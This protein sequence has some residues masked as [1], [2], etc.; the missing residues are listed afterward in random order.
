MARARPSVAGG[1]VAAPPERAGPGRPRRS[2]TGHRCDPERPGLRAVPRTPGPGAGRRA[3]KLR[4]GRGWWALLLLQLHLLRALAQDDVA[5]YFKTE[6]GLPQ[7]HLEGNRLVLTCLAEGSWP[8][9]FKWIRNDS[10]LTTYSSEYKYII[11]SLQKLDA[12]FYRCVVRNR[13]GALL[14]RKSEIQVAY[15]GNFMDTDQRKTVSQGHA[16]LLNL[17][18][19]VSCPRPQVTWF[20][21]GHKIIPSSRIAITL[22]N[23]LVILATTA[24]DAGAYYVQAVNERNGENKTSPFIHLSIA[25][26]TGTQEAMAPIIVVAPGNRS[27]VAGSSETT[28]ECIAN[29]RPVEEL[30]VHWKRNGVRLTSGLHSYGRRLTII[31]PTSADTGM[32]VCEATLRGSTFEPARAR[33]FLSII[34]PPYFTAE[35]ESR[36]LGEVEEAVDIP[37]RAMGVPL[38]TLQWYKDAVPLS[39]LQN[40]RYKVLPSGGLHIQKL[41]PEDSGIFQCFASNEGGEIQTHTYLDVT[42]IAPAFTQ[43]P[44]DTTVTDGMTAVLRCEVS[45]AP[46]PAIT[47]KRGNHI[48]ASGS[49]RIPR[50]MLLE[51][52]GLRIA[53]VFIQD[54]GNYTCY[55]ANTEASVNAS[56]MLT[57]WNRT[58]IVHPPEDRVVIK[59]TTATLCCGATHDPRTSLRYVWKK[60]NMVITAS[61]SSRIVVEKDGS[62]VISQTW[63]GDIGDYTCEIISEGGSDSRTARLEVIELPHPPQNLLA[64]LSPA[65]S[66]SV[67]LSWVRPFDGNSPVLY[68]IVQVSENNSPWKVHLSNVGPEMTGVTVSGLTPART[69]QFRVCAVNQ[70]GKGQYSTETSRLMLPEEPPSAPPKNIVASGRTNQSIMVQWQPPPETEHN[71]V[72]RGYILRYRLAGLPGEH[73]QRNISSPEVNYCLVTDLIIWTQYEIQVAAYNGAG[74]GVFSRAVTEYTLQGVPT[75][76]PQ[77]VQAEA[78]NSTT[79][80]FL[81]NPPPQQFIN[82]INQGYKLLAWPADAPETVTV[83]TIAPDFHGIH[84]GY[85]TNLKKFTAYFTSVLCFTTPGDGPPSSPQLVWTH[86]DKPGAVGH[87]SFT[88]IL[89]TSLKVSWQEPLERNGIIMGYQISWEVYGRNDSRLTHTLNST[90]HE[91]KIQGLSSLTTYT[92]DVAALTAAGV[93]VTTSSTISSGVP[94]DL[95]GAPSNLVISNISPR[96]AT[97]QF[98]PGYDGKTAICRWIVEGQVGAIGDEEEWVTLYEEENEPD[99][100]MLEI[101]NLTPYTHYRFRMRQVNI[102]GPSPFSQ[103]SRV[104]QTLQAPPDVAPTSL[105]VRTASET[106]LRL[107]WV[108]L[109][110]SQYNGNP[111]S[112]GYRVK[113]WRSD[114]PTSAL[115]QVVSDR[116]ERELTIEELEEWTEYELRM[117]AFNAIGAGPWS[118]L[119]RGRTRESV[120]SAAPENVSAEAVSSTQILLTWA[121]VPEQ[122]QNGLILGYKV[123][124]RAK[125]LDPEPRSHVVRG[126]H[127]QSALLAGLRKFVV[128][129]LQVL[130]FTRIGNGVPSS[131]LVLERTKDDTP[132]PPVRLVFP[133]VRLTAVRIVWQPPEEPNGVI[134]GYQIAY[135]LASGSPHTFTTVEVGATVRQFTATELAPESAYIFRLSAK[136]RQGWGEPLEATVITTEKRERP[137]PPRELLVPQAEVTARSLRLQW[138]PGS[139]GASPI[140]Y[141]TVQ[142]R[143]LPGGEWQTY[144]SSI[145]HE[146]TACAVERLR[147]FTSYKLRLKA[148]NDIGDSD[149]SV[150]TEAVTTLQDVPGEPPGSVSAT[151]HTTS[152]VLIQWQPPRDE[153]LNGLLQGYRIY[154]RELASETGMSPE[155]KTLQSPSALRAELTA[156][157]SFKTVNSSSSLTTYELT[158]LKKYRRYE[159]IM[160]AYNIIGESPASVPVEVFVGEAAPAMAPQ[161]VQVTPLT[162]SQLE[163][164]WDPP[165]PES[166]NGNIQ[167]YKV[168]YWEADSRNETEK[169]KVLFL[170]EPVVKIKDLTSHTKYLVSISAFNAAGDGPKS[171][172][173]QGRTHQA[174]PGTPSFLAFSEITSTTLNVSWG[175]PSAANGILQGYR[176]VYEPLAPVQGV[177]KVVTV[178]VK[179][180][181]QRWLKVRD[182]TK[183]VT[184]FFRV[185][186]RTIAYGPE[187]QANVTA[188][189]AEGSPG[190]PRNVLVTK[191]ASELTLQWIE[192]NAGTTPTTGYVIEARPSDEGLWDMFAKDIPRSATSYTVDLD[193]LRQGV[194]YEFRVVAVNKA[195][196]GEPSRPSIAVSAQAEAPFY[197]EWWFLL[198]M[199]LSSLLLI[200]LVVFVLVLHGQSKKYKNCSTGKG[201]SNM[202][203]T[204]TLD[205]GG[206]AALE[207]NSRHLNVKST[208]SK[209]NGTRS[210]PRPSPGGLHYSDEDICNKYNGAVLTESVN[211]KEKSVDGSESEASDSDY[212]EALPKHSFVNHYMSDPTYY[213]SWKRRPPAAAPHRYEAVAGAEAGPHLHT[214]ITTQ[215]AGGVYT[216]AGPGARAPLTGFSSFV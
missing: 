146:A 131:P 179:G 124:Y 134:L 196:F 171:D 164:T 53:P 149:F 176:V 114:Q 139:D 125:D 91:Y 34:E 197:E 127:T 42:N 213:N 82:G 160:T 136:T 4:P 58:S 162:A 29:A 144:S 150:E 202:E 169:M 41:S 186:A 152:S 88:E 201:I 137:A 3:A 97:L 72:L 70:V 173:C 188:G 210:P 193:K 156:Q 47:W 209:K 36:I 15:M 154:Y 21:E 166:Q 187:L 74:L 175:E 147:P 132:G 138:V 116:L 79:V 76:P 163:V 73:Q 106:S 38:P 102:V 117:Q 57:V 14:Q 159:V 215:S 33:A 18:P 94:P 110:D 64:S 5:P 200:L 90:T 26:D 119:V 32:Y 27:V 13:M 174:A 211:L 165:P 140:R 151:P 167:G 101:P 24:S 52:G 63:S 8:L 48:L 216:P 43:R 180:N 153:S 158:H 208:F 1:G 68:Y 205:N 170:P 109:P 148:T 100:Q 81:W 78:V 55:A 194:T 121:S 30:S 177:S 10:E 135:R 17:M 87:L 143:E 44:A 191:S 168:Y 28:L 31:N 69:Y 67:T 182:L 9:E 128:Y 142:V 25:R 49:V 199:A 61:S 51:S 85:I 6:P 189:P 155:P 80:H 35:P 172:P 206:F 115:A 77:N 178:D 108:P 86:E 19:I 198:V 40:P 22:E 20:R 118:E 204:V 89:D 54:A 50:F 75:A 59:G 145:S 98:R 62:L 130:A 181:R 113:Y 111:E 207:L 96:S 126:N 184:Y 23:Q 12:G 212:E 92:I 183:G 56:A 95:P 99:A 2:R 37:C 65:R 60:D 192:G 120:P 195:G 161:N 7:I 105:T 84:H 93:G 122:D 123:L 66:H 71:G 190:S 133:E 103:S 214:V 16:A 39:K 157:S 141:F 203:E 129:E 104:I 185:Q 107:R 112:V 45:G 83:V 11:P 46:K